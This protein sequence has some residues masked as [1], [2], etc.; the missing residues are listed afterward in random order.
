MYIFPLLVIR[1]SDNLTPLFAL[2]KMYSYVRYNR[3]SLHKQ[4]KMLNEAKFQNLNS[5]KNSR[6]MKPDFRE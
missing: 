4:I 3:E 5:K 2:D 1:R 6:K